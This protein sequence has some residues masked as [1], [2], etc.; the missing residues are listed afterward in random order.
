MIYKR[1]GL[2]YMGS[3]RKLAGKIIDKIIQDNGDIENFNDL[4]GGGGAVSFA[5]LQHPRIKNVHYNELNA[6]VVALLRDIIDN[7]VTAK[8]YQWIDR[9][10][11]H[12]HK[13]HNDWF[14][15]LCKVVWSFGN[16]QRSYL[17]GKHIEDERRLMHEIIV[18][19]S[20]HA[21][22]QLSDK[23][24]MEIPVP[25]GGLFGGVESRR[26]ELQKLTKKGRIAQ[27]LEHLQQLQRLKYLRGI[28][29]L[30]ITA[31]GYDKV[32]VHPSSIIYLDPPYDGTKQYEERVDH[33]ELLRW[34]KSQPNKIYVSGY[35]FDLPVV[36][37][38]KHRAI[39]S[40]TVNNEVTERLFLWEGKNVQQKRTDKKEQSQK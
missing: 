30:K 27:Y 8:Y 18:N 16:D 23:L 24:G 29:E 26:L 38:F 20:E 13:T 34:I 2:P 22:Q 7:G 40:A 28:K 15:G 4:F 12:E 17:F 1:L 21:A 37:E 11:F 36:A 19:K 39:V 6:G 31:K 25:Q 33:Q 14:G 32:A 3:K 5:A 35:E 9:D 10:T